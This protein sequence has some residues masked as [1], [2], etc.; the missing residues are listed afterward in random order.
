MLPSIEHVSRM[1]TFSAAMMLP[2]TLPATTTVFA[3]TAALT[4]PCSPTVSTFWFKLILAF[5]LTVDHQILVRAQLAFEDDCL[6]DGRDIV[7]SVMALL[8][9][10]G[11]VQNRSHFIGSVQPR[12]ESAR[13]IPKRG[14]ADLALRLA[15][16]SANYAAQGRRMTY[17]T[18]TRTQVVLIGHELDRRTAGGPYKQKRRTGAVSPLRRETAGH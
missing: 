5:D 12:S 13:L 2:R 11:C 10:V 14:M 1:P 9:S 7:L 6:A 3:T 15:P 8:P 16:P 4:F 18:R 17:C